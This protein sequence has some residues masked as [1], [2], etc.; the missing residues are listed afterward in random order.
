MDEVK[1]QEN[2]ILCLLLSQIFIKIFIVIV[3][4]NISQFEEIDPV[5]LTSMSISKSGIVHNIHNPT[6]F[7]LHWQWRI[8]SGFMG[9]I[10][11]CLPVSCFK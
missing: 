8:Q 4:E 7:N 1:R 11:T 6:K 9:F 3:L 5:R 2:H 10:R